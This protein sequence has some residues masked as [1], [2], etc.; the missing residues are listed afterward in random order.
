MLE[1]IVCVWIW[2]ITLSGGVGTCDIIIVDFVVI[3]RSVIRILVA[4]AQAVGPHGTK[5][6][7]SIRFGWVFKVM[8]WC[9]Q[10]QPVTPS[11]VR[12]GPATLGLNRADTHYSIHLPSAISTCKPN[13]R[14]T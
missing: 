14:T 4:W 2:S 10:H 9:E 13:P 5:M 3:P 1:Q 11:Q 8:L 6:F 12:I 7:Q